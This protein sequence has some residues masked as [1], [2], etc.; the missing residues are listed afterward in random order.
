MLK[1]FNLAPSLNKLSVV[2]I[3]VISRVHNIYTKESILL[4][5]TPVER[6]IVNFGVTTRC[7]GL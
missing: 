4:S 7:S 3:W 5:Y 6:R 1:I 2:C